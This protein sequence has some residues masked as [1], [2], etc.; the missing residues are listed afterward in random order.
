M[1][2]G[3]PATACCTTINKVCA[4]GLKSVALGAQSISLGNAQVVVAG[5]MESMTNAPYFLPKARQ[6]LKIG[7]GK[8]VD[9][10]M[11][12][13]LTDPFTSNPMGVLAEATAATVFLLLFWQVFNLQ[14]NVSREDMDAYSIES[15]Q[16]AAKKFTDGITEWVH[17]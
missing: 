5:G 12:D 13:G 16:K 9:S 2:A 11:F 15:Y 6:G 1:A 17:L 4:S 14:Y 10:M 3:L 7:D 8:I